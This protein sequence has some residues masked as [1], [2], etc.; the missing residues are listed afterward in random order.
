MLVRFIFPPN[1]WVYSLT[2]L[3]NVLYISTTQFNL[4]SQ[5]IVLQSSTCFLQPTWTMIKLTKLLGI[6][7][8]TRIWKYITSLFLPC[9]LFPTKPRYHQIQLW[10]HHHHHFQLAAQTQIQFQF[11]A[12]AAA[13][14]IKQETK[15]FPVFLSGFWVQFSETQPV[16]WQGWQAT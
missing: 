13:A 2:L 10:N 7:L 1:Q 11:L 5:E 16:G 15:T 6:L 12:E 9:F 3:Q 14:V 4:E 8:S